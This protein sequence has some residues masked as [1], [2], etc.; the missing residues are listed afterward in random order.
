[1]HF[2][3]QARDFVLRQAKATRVDWWAKFPSSSWA[4]CDLL[5]RILTFNPT[6]RIKVDEALNHPFLDGFPETVCYIFMRFD[7]YLY[8]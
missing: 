1:M 3:F 2:Y 5:D 7:V 4:S 6:K 8:V